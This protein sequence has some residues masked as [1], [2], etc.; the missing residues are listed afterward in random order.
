[1]PLY[2]LKHLNFKDRGWK[3][4]GKVLEKTAKGNFFQLK[5]KKDQTRGQRGRRA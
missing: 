1:M 3:S 5:R 2:I 4:W